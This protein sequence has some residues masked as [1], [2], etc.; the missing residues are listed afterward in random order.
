MSEDDTLRSELRWGGVALA[1][2]IVILAVI[3]FSA[4]AFAVHPPSNIETV[5]PATLHLRGE[6]I[7]SNLGTT[8]ADDGTI[9]VRIVATQ[10]TFV[11]RCAPVPAGRPVTIRMAAPDVVHGILVTGTNVNTMV[12]PGFVSEVRTVFEQ[13]G[14][15]LM[16]CHEYCGLGHS[17]MWGTIRV[18]PQSEWQVQPGKVGCAAR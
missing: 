13:P 18:L 16:P 12:V 15:L 2:L 6:F 5:D 9:T 4:I 17:E 8:V 7:E 14:D 10:F 1:A 11:P 3:I